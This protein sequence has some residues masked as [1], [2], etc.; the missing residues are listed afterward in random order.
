MHQEMPKRLYSVKDAARYLGV[1][2]WAVRKL[3][4]TGNLPHVR[5]GRRVLIDILDMNRF[6][7]A[8]K[9]EGHHGDDLSPQEA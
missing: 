1:S 6:I 9:R 8:N 5:Q 4:W 2:P 3:I 7:E